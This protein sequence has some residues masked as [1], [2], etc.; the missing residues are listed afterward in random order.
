MSWS[1][2]PKN[3]GTIYQNENSID[4]IFN[5]YIRGGMND[6]NGDVFPPFIPIIGIRITPP[7]FITPILDL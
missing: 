7:H 4:V 1:F 6:A 5:K 3:F 2:F